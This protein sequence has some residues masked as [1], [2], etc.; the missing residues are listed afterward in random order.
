M[1]RISPRPF[2]PTRY[3]TSGAHWPLPLPIA[4]STLLST[5]RYSNILWFVPLPKPL[6]H[7]TAPDSY[8]KSQAKWSVHSDFGIFACAST[9]CNGS[10]DGICALRSRFGSKYCKH[11]SV[12]LPK[13]TH[14]QTEHASSITC[15]DRERRSTLVV[16]PAD[17]RRVFFHASKANTDISEK[18]N[19]S[20]T[21][22]SKRKREENRKARSKKG[23][24]KKGEAKKPNKRNRHGRYTEGEYGRPCATSALDR[25]AP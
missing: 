17:V 11:L 22:E 12:A 18:N 5:L 13:R 1:A 25:H 3:R 23:K 6:A 9:R 2:S 19:E 10:H 15:F 4:L 16:V 7:L 21:Q 14:H 20:E 24:G 8:S